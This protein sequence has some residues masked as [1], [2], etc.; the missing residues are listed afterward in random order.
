MTDMESTTL[1]A[2]EPSVWSE[3]DYS[4]VPD[5]LVDGMKKEHEASKKREKTTSKK[6]M[7]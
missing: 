4:D 5:H 7:E 3:P 1:E 2:S 6:G